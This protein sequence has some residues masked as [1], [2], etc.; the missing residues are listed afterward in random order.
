VPVAEGRGRCTDAKVG[1]KLCR[2]TEGDEKQD[3]RNDDLFHITDC[4]KNII[5]VSQSKIIRLFQAILIYQ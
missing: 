2:S 5:F 4:I 3:D 1:M